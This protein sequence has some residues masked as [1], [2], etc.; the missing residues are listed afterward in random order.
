MRI[1]KTKNEN[2]RNDGYDILKSLCAFLVVCI[3]TPFSGLFGECVTTI[4]RIAV[5]IFFLISGYFFNAS[6]D[7]QKKQI[8]KVFVLYSISNLLYCLIDFINCF[9]RGQLY[10]FYSKFSITSFLKFIIFNES[11]FASHLWYLGAILY[12]R[13]VV[14]LFYSFFLKR[15]RL[16][17]FLIPILLLCD[18]VFGKYSLVFFDFNIPFILVR[19]FLFVGIPYFVIGIYLK[20][21]NFEHKRVSHVSC[22][23]CIFL[24]ILFILTSLVEHFILKALNLNAVRDHYLSTTFLAITVFYFFSGKKWNSTKYTQLPKYVGRNLSMY[25]YII[26]PIFISLFKVFISLFNI[27]C[28]ILNI[29][30]IFIFLVSAIFSYFYY[31]VICY[32]KNKLFKP[33]EEK[34]SP[35]EMS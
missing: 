27:D 17:Y 24:G 33:G 22:F 7:I 11:P 12:V 18:L 8:K 34:I 9:I 23:I 31:I 3:H 26:H 1:Y 5:P 14:Y 32:F 20:N 15:A 21:N 6:V 4:S 10:S 28:F 19:N 30:P 35:I 2:Q 25:I 13:L 16:L 29:K